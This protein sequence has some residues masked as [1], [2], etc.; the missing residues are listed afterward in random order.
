MVAM[1]LALTN[2]LNGLGGSIM[3][4]QFETIRL[5]AEITRIR[6][7]TRAVEGKHKRVLVMA[8][9]GPVTLSKRS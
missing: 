3:D 1:N 8:L 6:T 7:K 5:L 2:L 4:T 9:V